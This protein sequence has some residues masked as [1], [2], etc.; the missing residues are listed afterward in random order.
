MMK[1]RYSQGLICPFLWTI[2][3]HFHTFQLYSGLDNSPHSLQCPNKPQRNRPSLIPAPQ[4]A[5]LLE[6]GEFPAQGGQAGGLGTDKLKHI[7]FE[8]KKIKMY[9]L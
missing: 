2:S 3:E 9:G 7:N 1:P 8:K 6:A 5:S 4:A